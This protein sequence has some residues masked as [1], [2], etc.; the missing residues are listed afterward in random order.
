LPYGYAAPIRV[1]REENTM[2]NEDGLSTFLRLRP[3]LLAIARRMLGCAAAAEDIVQDVWVRWQTTDRTV[4]RDP[5]AYLAT[6]TTRMAI[7]VMQSAHA[8]RE[9]C[10]DSLPDPVD[11][12]ANPAAGAERS[13]GLD[14]AQALLRETLSPTE[15]AAFVLREAFELAYRDIADVLRLQEANARQVVTR[16]RQRLANRRHIRAL[17]RHN[18]SPY[19]V[20]G[21]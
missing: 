5:G 4:V 2:T 13:D 15:R 16:A 17:A 14:H 10:V 19:P 3:R 8:R 20:T 6:A 21:S 11:T 18:G 9:T 12:G 1:A 7:N